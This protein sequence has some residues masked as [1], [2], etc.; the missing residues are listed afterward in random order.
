MNSKNK[1]IEQWVRVDVILHDK[2][3]KLETLDA[4]REILIEEAE[5]QEVLSPDM[6]EKLNVSFEKYKKLASEIRDLK[7]KID[8]LQ[9]DAKVLH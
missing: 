3:Q 8:Q 2:L 5:Q 4:E 7:N 6:E 1:K 9:S